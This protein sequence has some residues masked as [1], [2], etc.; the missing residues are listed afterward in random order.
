MLNGWDL[1]GEKKR[2]RKHVNVILGVVGPA[3]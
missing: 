1:K 2:R 3:E